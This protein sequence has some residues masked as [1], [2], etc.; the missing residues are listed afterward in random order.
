M[1]NRVD[2]SLLLLD[3]IPLRPP[4]LFFQEILRWLF[5]EVLTAIQLD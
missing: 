2:Q 5:I 1:R 3:L 4:P